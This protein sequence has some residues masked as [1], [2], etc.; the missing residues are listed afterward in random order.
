[1]KYRQNLV[2]I[3]ALLA[4]AA[5]TARVVDAP[6]GVNTFADVQPGAA[7]INYYFDADRPEWLDS[8]LSGALKIWNDALGEERLHH[9][10]AGKALQVRVAF[11]EVD[12]LPAHPGTTELLGCMEGFRHLSACRIE[13]SMPKQ[14]DSAAMLSR[15]SFLFRA[16]PLD[17]HLHQAKTY[18]SVEEFLRDKL[19]LMVLVHEIGHTLGL[20]HA[21]NGLNCLMAAS[22][23]ADSGLCP[24]EIK[25][26]RTKLAY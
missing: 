23:K 25:A 13:L 20:E 10:Q 16:G 24:S 15:L 7:H 6:D 3:V 9:G 22:P 4:L 8:S 26:A 14:V 2:L 12:D 11:N 21:R 1:M 18:L 19:A 5:C 17:Q